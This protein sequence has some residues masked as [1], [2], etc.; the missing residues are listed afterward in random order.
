MLV[1]KRREFSGE[2]W[3]KIQEWCATLRTTLNIFAKKNTLTFSALTALE[4][5]N[6]MTDNEFHN[7]LVKIIRH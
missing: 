6:P 5:Q 7:V 2:A 3:S 1:R 4:S